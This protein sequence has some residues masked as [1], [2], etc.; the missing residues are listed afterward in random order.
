MNYTSELKAHTLAVKRLEK[1][2][3]TIVA[4]GQD[5][6]MVMALRRVIPE[7]YMPSAWKFALHLLDM[8]SDLDTD[9]IAELVQDITD[10]ARI[11]YSLRYGKCYG[12]SQATVWGPPIDQTI[13]VWVDGYHTSALA[14]CP[15]CAEKWRVP[16]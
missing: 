2:L 8:K 10:K 1:H 4:V 5:A 11:L 15:T 3:D 12:C 6:F 9:A 7:L 13:T 14:F 16:E